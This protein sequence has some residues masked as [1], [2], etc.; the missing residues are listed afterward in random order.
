MNNWDL[1]DVSSKPIVGGLPLHRDRAPLYALARSDS[2]WERRIAM[3]GCQWFLK[4]GDATMCSRW[5][6]CC[7]VTGTT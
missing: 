6:S 1:V 3:V 7:W 2:L 4:S 5:P